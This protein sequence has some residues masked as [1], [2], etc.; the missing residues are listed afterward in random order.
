MAVVLS[1]RQNRGQSNQFVIC[2]DQFT[3]NIRSKSQ[4]NE[5]NHSSVRNC[6][7]GEA[8]LQCTMQCIDRYRIYITTG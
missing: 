6:F 8:L 7:H 4:G 3:L 1:G 5:V 2:I